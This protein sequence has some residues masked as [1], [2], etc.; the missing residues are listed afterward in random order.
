MSAIHP[1][2]SHGVPFDNR[3]GNSGPDNYL[4]HGKGIKSWLFTLDHKRIGL[5][6]MA[7]ILTFF[8]VGGMFAMMVRAELFTPGPTFTWGHSG[9]DGARIAKDFYNNMF[10]LHGAV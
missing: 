4:T 8:F 3:S 2:I 5:M 10:T 1:P 6:Y 9:D 7:S